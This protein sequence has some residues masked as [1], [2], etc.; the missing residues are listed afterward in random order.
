MNDIHHF[1]K[2]QIFGARSSVGQGGL[3]SISPGKSQVAKGFPRNTG[4]EPLD[5]L[6]PICFS[7]EV[8]TSLK[9]MTENAP[10]ATEF[11]GS[12]H[13][14]YGKHFYHIEAS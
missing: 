10:P 5:P 14:A 12:T 7:R 6:D 1:G 9:L 2:G 13:V 4:T 8:P 11:S 3:D